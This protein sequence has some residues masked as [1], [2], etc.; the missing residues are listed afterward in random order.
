MDNNYSGIIGQRINTALA[1]SNV[2]Q[3][4]LAKEL[5]VK[6]NVVSYWCSGS[7]TPNTEQIIKISK[8]LNVSSDYLLG[9]SD[10]ATSDK[11]LQFICDYLGLDEKA[12]NRIKTNKYENILCSDLDAIA[13]I[14]YKYDDD[15]VQT[16]YEY[17]CIDSSSVLSE[18]KK[19]YSDILNDFLSSNYFS[20]LLSNVMSIFL[21]YKKFEELF[22]IGCGNFEIFKNC[23]N[24]NEIQILL[25][26][27]TDFD[28]K[29]YDKLQKLCIYDCQE[30][31]TK[32][33]KKYITKIDRTMEEEYIF[34]GMDII[35][36]FALGN[37]LC[38]NNLNSKE[39]YLTALKKQ[40]SHY[41]E[42]FGTNNITE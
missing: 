32:F 36:K 31:I 19:M 40:F 26:L 35:N 20:Y 33:C 10:A 17:D 9:L 37:V 30:N 25:H 15:R 1:L 12:I 23:N 16:Q 7:R 38:N 2:K 28:L 41:T 22:K 13:F 8:L 34:K 4:E 18:F 27:L 24:A 5:G 42:W 6:D 11:D 14:D 29:D 3:K 39:D 21:N